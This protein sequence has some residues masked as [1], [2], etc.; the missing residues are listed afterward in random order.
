MVIQTPLSFPFPHISFYHHPTWEMPLFNSL[1]QTTNV[2]P[3]LFPNFL[4]PYQIPDAL[5]NQVNQQE[6]MPNASTS[7]GESPPLHKQDRELR[8]NNEPNSEGSVHSEEGKDIELQPPT[9]IRSMNVIIWN[10]RGCNGEDFR[11]RFRA[12]LDWHKAPLVVLV[13]T[14]MQDH[15]PLLDD[16]TFN[17][18][19]QLPENGNSRGLAVL[20]DDTLLE[21][22]DIATIGQ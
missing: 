18:M 14:K 7:P 10:G 3:L 19:I 6:T 17:N 1:N 15:Q 22:D 13:E 5:M 9:L 4:Y 2:E 12:L 11:R 8:C 21:L 20:W 16:F